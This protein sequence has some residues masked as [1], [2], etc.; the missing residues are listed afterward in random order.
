MLDLLC[1]KLTIDVNLVDHVLQFSFRRCLS[2]GA[3]DVAEL[4]GRDESI[5]IFVEQ[6]KDF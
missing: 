2:Q 3:H 6:Q 5:A 1:V 4:L